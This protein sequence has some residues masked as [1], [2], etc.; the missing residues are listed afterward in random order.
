MNTRFVFLLLLLSACG[1]SL[2]D[3][4]RKQM[5]EARQNKAIQR[6]TDAELT[7]AAFNKGREI[8]SVAK[9]LKQNQID[10]LATAQEVTIH[11]LEPGQAGRMIESQLIEAYIVNAVTGNAQA[12]NLQRIGTDSL[13]YTMP[14]TDTLPDG[15]ISV[16][17]TWNIWMAKRTVVLSLQD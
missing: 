12:D 3:E 13:L 7:E 16:K 10:S 2:S 9:K 15:V 8:L 14:V 5:K 1:G 11:W 4:Q 6:V 17:G